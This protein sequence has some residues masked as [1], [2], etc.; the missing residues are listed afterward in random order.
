MRYPTYH[1]FLNQRYQP[2]VWDNGRLSI[3]LQSLLRRAAVRYVIS[4]RKL[5]TSYKDLGDSVYEDDQTLPRSYI[6]SFW[7]PHQDRRSVG[8]WLLGAGVDFPMVPAIEGAQP[9]PDSSINV[10]TNAS[11]LPV[12]VVDR[13]NYEVRQSVVMKTPGWL[14]LSDAWD[15][16]WRVTVDGQPAEI[17]VANGYQRAVWLTEGAR[18]VVWQYRP[19]GLTAGVLV[20]LI[21]WLIL[22]VMVLPKALIRRFFS[23]G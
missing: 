12:D 16:G 5:R 15:P 19:P 23:L 7:V 21:A 3:G 11:V 8:R 20:S 13:S 9:P 1:Q 14:I 6:A 10:A 22:A 2:D 4:S 17:H 18:E